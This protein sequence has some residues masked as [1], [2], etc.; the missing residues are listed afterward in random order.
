MVRKM[1]PRLSRTAAIACCRVRVQSTMLSI[2]VFG[3]GFRRKDSSEGRAL[4]SFHRLGPISFIFLIPKNLTQ[5]A[6]VKTRGNDNF[7]LKSH[8]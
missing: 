2:R 3:E 5:T 6:G 7:A 8:G 4:S 1:E